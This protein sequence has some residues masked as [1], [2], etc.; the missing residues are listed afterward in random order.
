VTRVNATGTTGAFTANVTGLT[1]NTA[2]S[3]KAFATNAAWTAY[4]PVAT[5]TSLAAPAPEIA[6][7][8]QWHRHLRR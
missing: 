4:S 5:F 2:Y 8:W 6:V 7:T 3:F 1:P